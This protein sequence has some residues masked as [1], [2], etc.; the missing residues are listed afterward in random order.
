V[1]EEC[2]TALGAM[3]FLTVGPEPPERLATVA[4]R[5][6]M[7]GGGLGGGCSPSAVAS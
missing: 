3:Q 7:E 5:W 2:A 4:E 6:R 1:A